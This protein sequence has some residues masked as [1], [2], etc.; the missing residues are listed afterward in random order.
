MLIF[1]V[2]ADL[3]RR[4]SLDS[5]RRR[6]QAAGQPTL[7]ERVGLKRLQLPDR[8]TYRGS[9]LLPSWLPGLLNNGAVLL[10]GFQ[11]IVIYVVSALWKIQGSTWLEG[12]AVYYPLR[13]E[14]LTLFSEL[15]EV[16]W[17]ITPLVVISTWA[18]VYFQLF[19]PVL[20]LNRWT[21]IFAILGI[22]GMHIGIAVLLSL[23]FF[24]AVMLLA[25]AV[26]VRDST[27]RWLIDWARARLPGARPRA[28]RGRRRAV[29]ER[30][31]AIG[32]ADQPVV[33]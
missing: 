29:G 14:E 33:G 8:L 11:L 20:L 1:L 13:V 28:E 19:F 17:H 10:I 3:S 26:F 2:F 15:N 6:R 32:T 4:W 5:R 12:H 16:L 24:S 9:P 25:D 22:T 23:P 31:R 18:T 30:G 27:W 21:R 7:L